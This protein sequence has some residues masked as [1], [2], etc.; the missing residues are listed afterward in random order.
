MKALVYT[1]PGSAEIR[2]IPIDPKEN[3]AMIKVRFAGLCGT[4][5]NIFNGKHPRAK[6]P[7]V[8]GHE[9]SGEIAHIEKNDLGLKENDRVAVN[10]VISCG[11]CSL[12]ISGKGNICKKL[13]L[14]G[15][16][17]DGGFAEYVNVP[18]SR[19]HKIDDEIDFDTAALIEPLAVGIRGYKKSSLSESSH[20]AISGG[21]SI[22]MIVALVLENMG[23][24]NI[25]IIEVND[26]RL[27]L[28]EKLGFKGVDASKEDVEA[29]FS[30]STNAKGVDVLFEASGAPPALKNMT[31]LVAPSGQIV[32]LSVFKEPQEVNLLDINFKELDIFGSRMYSDKDFAE[33]CVMAKTLQHKLKELIIPKIALVDSKN[34]FDNN[35]KDSLKTLIDCTVV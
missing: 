6:A 24:R 1:G 2:E 34:I 21:G 14:L 3:H 32:L 13:G 15:I 23:I 8:F 5:I 27:R 28:I 7:L 33:A 4:D 35:T 16:D 18:L 20:V 17:W 22:G 30:K 31:K 26:F 10:P 29:Y 19:I 12:C 25:S 11:E 9:F